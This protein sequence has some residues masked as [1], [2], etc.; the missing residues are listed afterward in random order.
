MKPL[1]CFLHPRRAAAE[2]H[3]L[4]TEKSDADARITELGDSARDMERK[5]RADILASRDEAERL[6]SELA[7]TVKSLEMVS[8]ELFATRRNLDQAEKRARDADEAAEAV[9]AMDG[10]LQEVKKIHERFR[11]RIRD[12][13][14]RL[15]DANRRLQ[16]AGNEPV[17]AA[18]PTISMTAEADD[19]PLPADGDWLQPLP[20]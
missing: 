17:S 14:R 13:T 5:L 3:R 8:A 10:K 18:P 12:L 9:E 11:G 15:A 1:D 2:I 19:P 6:R 4:E 16:D 20:D 7:R